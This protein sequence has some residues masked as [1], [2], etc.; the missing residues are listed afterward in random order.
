MAV[1]WSIQH[2]EKANTIPNMLILKL[3]WY[4]NSVTLNTYVYILDLCHYIVCS[5]VKI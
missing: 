4:L 1:L 3:F 2:V 5:V